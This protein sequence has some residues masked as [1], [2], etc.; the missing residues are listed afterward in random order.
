M[1][2]PMF[3]WT[4]LDIT[5]Y[6][7]WEQ[8]LQVKN[9]QLAKVN[10]QMEKFLYSTSHDLRSPITSILGLVNLIRM[11]T[12]D[13]TALE[14]ASKIETSANKLDKIIRDIMSYSR[15]TYQRIKSEH[16]DFEPLIWKIINNYQA[17]PALGKINVELS[18]EGESQYY[19]DVER[20][21]LI[22]DNIFRNSLH[23]FDQNKARSFI[24]IQVV[25]ND[26]QASI[27]VAD[28][29]IGIGKDHIEQ[30]FN[31]FYKATSISKGAGLGLF[32]VKESLAKLKG[33]IT[34]ESEI[35]FGSV[36]RITLPNDHKGKLINRKLHLQQHINE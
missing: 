14:Y 15:S 28:N 22:I 18:V 4:A 36:F 33:T 6:K 2:I 25:L 21:E 27:Q 13:K 16:I 20:V 26:K 5:E 3:N 12:A 24:K 23:F 35:G 9:E 34:V 32:I 31:M 30:I 7:A 19:N 11:E 10:Q 1:G 29:G 17:D 8:H